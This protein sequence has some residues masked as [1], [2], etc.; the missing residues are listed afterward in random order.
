MTFIL[1]VNKLQNTA[2]GVLDA[3]NTQL[4]AVNKFSLIRKVK[5]YTQT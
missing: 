3:E 2:L 5:L 1:P 4:L